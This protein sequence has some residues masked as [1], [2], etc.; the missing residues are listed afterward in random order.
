[1][2]NTIH[3]QGDTIIVVYSTIKHYASIQGDTIILVYSTS[4]N[5]KTT[6]S[7]FH[8]Y[9]Y[10]DPHHWDPGRK[11]KCTNFSHIK[12]IKD[13][14]T[15]IRLE[16]DRIPVN[17]NLYSLIASVN[18]LCMFKINYLCFIM[19]LANIMNLVSLL[20]SIRLMIIQTFINVWAPAKRH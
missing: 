15:N 19:A 16:R 5:H 17:N 8:L 7:T 11:T 4:N 6:F 3:I 9:I 12:R 20:I 18:N 2:L 10:W 1:M 14:G 13:I